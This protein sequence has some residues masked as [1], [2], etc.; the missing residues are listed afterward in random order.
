M[1]GLREFG[2]GGMLR[3]G[4]SALLWALT[5]L[6]MAA[7]LADGA[8]Q[9][10]EA[11]LTGF[12]PP[13]P[14]QYVIESAESSGEVRDGVAI[15]NITA[16][17]RVFRTEWTEAPL[18]QGDF[19]VTAASAES[20]DKSSAFIKRTGNAYALHARGKTTVTVKLTVACRLEDREGQKSVMLPL[21]QGLAATT[22]LQLPAENVRFATEPQ[23]DAAL[24]PLKDG[25]SKVTIYGAAAQAVRLSWS[26]QPRLDDLA[27]LMFADHDA[28][29]EVSRGALRVNSTFAFRVIQGS[30]QTLTLS[31]PARANL[32]SVGGEGIRRWDVK[33]ENGRS[34]LVVE[35]AEKIRDTYRL[36]LTTET[37]VEGLPA[38]SE[39]PLAAA[40]NVRREKGRISIRSQKGIKVE[41]G[42]TRNVTQVDV[43]ELE[44]EGAENVP[45]RAVIIGIEPAPNQPAP[46]VELPVQSQPVARQHPVQQAD[47]LDNNNGV[48]SRYAA[49]YNQQNEQALVR[50]SAN[51]DNWGWDIRR[52][53]DGPQADLAFRFLSRPLAVQ[54]KIS[55]VNPKVTASV[56]TMASVSREN[57]R[58]LHTIDYTIRE[59]GVFRFSVRIPEGLKLLDVNGQ[60][61]NTWQMDKN[62]LGVDLRVKAEGAYALTIET[63]QQVEPDKPLALLEPE[64]VGVERE[65]GYI[66]LASR[67]GAKIELASV[68]TGGATQIDAGE[69]PQALRPQGR[70][71]EL[72]F[73]YIRHPFGITLNVGAIEPEVIATTANLLT[74]DERELQLETNV[75][76]DIRKSGIF[77]IRLAFPQGW[78]LSDDPRGKTIE[79]WRLDAS[80]NVL[81]LTF[82]GKI[83][84]KAQFGVRAERSIDAPGKEQAFPAFSVIGAKKETGFLAVATPLAMRMSAAPGSYH[85]LNPI[86]TAELPALLPAAKTASAALA[87]KYLKG[88][89]DL[90]VA[91]EEIKPLVTAQI[92]N[93]ADISSTLVATSAQ[94]RY[95]I[96][97]AGTDTFY[98]QFPK[99]A[100]SIDLAGQNIKTRA[101]ADA[102]PAELKDAA[103]ADPELGEVWKV[104][105]QEKVRG[106]YQLAATFERPLA[107]E[108]KTV[109][110]AGVRA[111]GVEREEGY[112]GLAASANVEVL[113]DAGQTRGAAFRV[114]VRQI[115]GL[116]QL[117][118]ANPVIWAFQYNARPYL[119][120]VKV[121]KH[122]DVAVVTAVADMAW[123]ETVVGRDG[124]S[125]TDLF[126]SMRNNSQQYLHLLLPEGA[127]L[128]EAKVNGAV[129]PPSEEKTAQGRART[130]IPIAE[131]SRGGKPF[132]VTVRYEQGLGGLGQLSGLALDA[133]VMS[134][135]ILRCVWDVYLPEEFSVANLGGDMAVSDANDRTGILNYYRENRRQIE[136]SARLQEEEN[137]RNNKVAQGKNAA[138]RG[139]DTGTSAVSGKVI[140]RYEKTMALNE[141]LGKESP[142]KLRLSVM[143]DAF[144]NVLTVLAALLALGAAALLWRRPLRARVIVYGAAVLVLYMLDTLA[145]NFYSAQVLALFLVAAAAFVV[146]LG[147]A[148]IGY[149]CSQYGKAR[150]ALL[151]RR[152]ACAASSENALRRHLR[153]QQTT[154]PSNG[155]VGEAPLAAAPAPE[156]FETTTDEASDKPDDAASSQTEGDAQPDKRS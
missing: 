3:A 126:L 83:T 143:R 109:A 84:G 142:A 156:T 20:E 59:A 46:L 30:V 111:L 5:L 74:I 10:Q 125:T 154:R 48:N 141:G 117:R 124:Q 90:T 25:K 133:P 91:L 132:Q 43:A 93:I 92:V 61:L 120:D 37:A 33:A 4:M 139:L 75:E 152:E 148:V 107:K 11:G 146:A 101:V 31:L 116:E 105:L 60:N 112:V 100:R 64:L 137:L 12:T 6:L 147:R 97:Q 2:Q 118:Q 96:R 110:Y 58:S 123:F 122:D 135:P 8:A 65:T 35:L 99:N 80:S 113:P 42:E 50:A 57:V 153:P 51:N 23:T 63:E 62:T 150:E 95:E 29:V 73:R 86:P 9:A 134:I 52:G 72:G 32:L 82:G 85:G 13:A 49:R 115:P 103:A 94:I 155:R 78:R 18:L 7:G 140:H 88:G 77:E 36:R 17:V 41:P 149:A 19:S 145:E 71:I 40:E 66:A 144:S 108:D 104:V 128:W 34:L 45:P 98:V 27:P 79:D 121:T 47:G 68:P 24:E 81:T 22:T 55:E 130:L 102:L 26:P 87:F 38:Q 89:W 76:L 21:V 44:D 136:A 114:D 70:Q 56:S 54:L 119:L 28:A 106:G 39:L 129:V 69:L 67:G 14:A 151:Q 1:S 131:A 53:T 127:K 138:S 16:K 15:L